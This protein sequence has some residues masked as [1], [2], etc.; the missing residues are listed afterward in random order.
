[1]SDKFPR[2]K[3]IDSRAV[4]DVTDAVSALIALGASMTRVLTEL[5][6]RGASTEIVRGMARPSLYV[7][8]HAHSVR[9]PDASIISLARRGS[10][11]RILAAL[12]CQH[13]RASGDALSVVELFEAGWPGE[14]AH[15]EAAAARVYSTI[16]TLRNLGLRPWILGR[17]DGYL[18][19]TELDVQTASD[20][21][22]FA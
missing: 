19:A 15:P 13:R 10:A 22:L 14:R 5:R 3:L 9:L 7:G 1:M 2:Y 6:E 12:V 8:V 11:R 4:H 16:R 20:D 17:D 21:L 18:L